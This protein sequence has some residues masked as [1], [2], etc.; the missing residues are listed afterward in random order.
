M[1]NSRL[2]VLYTGTHYVSM[3]IMKN[4]ELSAEILNEV[5]IDKPH[6]NHLIDNYSVMEIGSVLGRLWVTP[7][8]QGQP[9]S[10]MTK[11]SKKLEDVIVG[12]HNYYSFFDLTGEEYTI[13]EALNDL[14]SEP[15][16]VIHDDGEVDNENGWFH[17]IS[18]SLY[19]TRYYQRYAA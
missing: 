18:N 12:E 14:S 8:S 6:L 10:T 2:I 1:T 17:C 4:G 3:S 15:G 11:K 13:N 5:V 16:I 7:I 19:E 9:N